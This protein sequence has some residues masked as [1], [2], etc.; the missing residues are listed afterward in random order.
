MSKVG[1]QHFFEDITAVHAGTTELTP[2]DNVVTFQSSG[3][4]SAGTGLLEMNIEASND[5][6]T[7]EAVLQMDVVLSTTDSCTLG[8]LNV[9]YKYFRCNLYTVTGTDATA[10]CNMGIRNKA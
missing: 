6:D 2:T 9:P 3:Y 8:S 7:W 4:T 1:V 5:G 10:S